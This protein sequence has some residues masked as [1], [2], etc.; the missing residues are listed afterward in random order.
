MVVDDE[1]TEYSLTSLNCIEAGVFLTLIGF[2]FLFMGF[3][4]AADFLCPYSIRC[5][6]LIC[7]TQSVE[8]I[9]QIEVF[10]LVVATMGLL[11]LLISTFLLIV[12]LSMV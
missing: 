5:I 1:A 2:P 11:V 12:S 10:R 9:R 3:C 7:P 4:C 6:Q 8:T